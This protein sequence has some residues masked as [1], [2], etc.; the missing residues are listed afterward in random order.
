MKDRDVARRDALARLAAMERRGEFATIVYEDPVLQVA[1]WRDVV[2]QR[3]TRSGTIE[4]VRALRRVQDDIFN[5]KAKTKL[6][7]VAWL[8]LSQLTSLDEETRKALN[9]NREA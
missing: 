4:N 5:A 2:V 7:L 9:E 6:Y 3:W 8:Q 1:T